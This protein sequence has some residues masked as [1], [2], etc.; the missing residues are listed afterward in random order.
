MVGT[1][2]RLPAPFQPLKARLWGDRIVVLAE[3]M[4]GDG[5]RSIFVRPAD[6]PDLELV[7]LGASC[8]VVDFEHHP[9]LGGL[10][11][12]VARRD[13]RALYEH[14][15]LRLETT[16]AAPRQI[17]P[18]AGTTNVWPVRFMGLSSD[19]RRLAI[20]GGELSK[21]G[22]RELVRYFVFLVDAESGQYERSV[23]LL[24]VFF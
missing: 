11:A 12:L 7:D 21:D 5:A 1:P 10:C 16:S 8:D 20:A 3:K 17:F 15:L 22:D 18:P 23:E 14:R 6:K 4:S 19:G 2:L 24:G 13:G 9:A